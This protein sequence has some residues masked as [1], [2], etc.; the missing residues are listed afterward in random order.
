MQFLR[1]DSNTIMIQDLSQEYETNK[2][3]LRVH[4]PARLLKSQGSSSEKAKLNT[5]FQKKPNLEQIK[6]RAHPQLTVNVRKRVFS[7]ELHSQQ[8]GSHPILQSH[9]SPS[10]FS[11]DQWSSTQYES[12]DAKIIAFLDFLNEDKENQSQL[13]NQF[14][15]YYLSE[16]PEIPEV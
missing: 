4:S 11:Q 14:D 16:K 7:H 6:A 13:I 2:E 3:L 12:L 8:I 10:V 9:Q 1:K 15:D 5:S